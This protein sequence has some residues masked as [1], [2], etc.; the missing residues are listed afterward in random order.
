LSKLAAYS[1]DSGTHPDSP[2]ALV[3][4]WVSPVQQWKKLARE[5]KKAKVEFGFQTL[6]MSEL[7]ANNPKSEFADRDHWNDTRKARLLKTL[8]EIVGE[9][10][11]Q[12][13]EN[14]VLKIDY[15][16]LVQ[17]ENRRHL[18]HFHY[19]YAVEGCL[20]AIEKWRTE[21]IVREPTQYIFDRMAKGSAKKEIER[22]FRDAERLDSPLRRYGIYTGCQSFGDKSEIIP[23]QAADLLAWC[24]FRHDRY[25]I[26]RLSFPSEAVVDTWNYFVNHGLIAKYQTR[27]QLAEF[28]AK[29][30]RRKFSP[31]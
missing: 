21:N 11:G 29:N 16:D 6:H 27:Q 7:M 18:G 28:A 19:T 26:H 15:D 4:G 13:F 23:L 25:R 9:H 30:P 12:G 5:W 17:G 10:G 2:V 8:R 22:T 3:A 24:A 14:S 1:D 20:S 31:S